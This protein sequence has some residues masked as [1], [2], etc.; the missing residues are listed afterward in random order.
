MDFTAGQLRL[1]AYWGEIQSG[2]SQRVS[3]ADLWS[4]VRDAAAAEGRP[5]SGVSAIDMNLLRSI[6]AEQQRTM[7]DLGALRPDQ[8]LDASVIARDVSA[9]PLAEQALAP[10]FLVRFEHDLI[11]EGE[12]MTVWRTSTFD[13]ALPPTSGDLRNALELD[14]QQMIENSSGGFGPDQTQHAGIGRMQISAV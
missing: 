13:G 14:A 7:R 9:R 1:L 2:V 6:A 3:T 12:L 8:G 5:L 10:Q 4:I 11:V